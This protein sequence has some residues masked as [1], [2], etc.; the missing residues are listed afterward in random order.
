MKWDLVEPI[1]EVQHAASDDELKQC[2]E[3]GKNIA[4]LL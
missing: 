3:L 2:R 4:R 1:I